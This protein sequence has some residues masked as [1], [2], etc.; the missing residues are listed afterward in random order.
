MRPAVFLDRDGTITSSVQGYVNA[1]E[2]LKLIPGI[3]DQLKRLTELDYSLVVV[4]NQAGVA[5]GY[6]SL[7][8]AIEINEELLRQ[9][10]EKDVAVDGIYMCPH[11]GSCEFRKPNPGML[12]AAAADL[13][14]DLH[15]SWMIGDMQT[16]FDAG[17][18][19]GCRSI[20]LD[21]STLEGFTSAVDEIARHGKI[22]IMEPETHC[23]YSVI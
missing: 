21:S 20:I 17:E 16:D 22:V 7:E 11:S 13:H 5:F 3:E 1:P 10:R 8:A 12:Y 14:I 4:T 18:C 2:D 15:Q 23:V 9:L 19:A 6:L